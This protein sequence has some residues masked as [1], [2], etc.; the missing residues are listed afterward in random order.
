VLVQLGNPLAVS[1][2]PPAARHVAH[3]RRVAHAH[4]WAVERNPLLDERIPRRCAAAPSTI[5]GSGMAIVRYRAMPFRGPPWN[6]NLWR[7]T[8]W[9]ILLASGHGSL[10]T[11]KKLDL[12]SGPSI[13]GPPARGVRAWQSQQRVAL[14]SLVESEAVVDFGRLRGLAHHLPPEMVDG[15]L[16]RTSETGLQLSG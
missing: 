6:P 13:I 2:V 4:L 16:P 14:A 7:M 3:V 1:G 9:G 8:G 5:P 12:L 10:A 15:Q 11:H